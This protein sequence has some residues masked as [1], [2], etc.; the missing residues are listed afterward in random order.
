MIFKFQQNSENRLEPKEDPK[1]R[2]YKALFIGILAG[3]LFHWFPIYN[4]FYGDAPRHL[5]LLKDLKHM[6]NEHLE[7]LV[8]T[9]CFPNKNWRND[10]FEPI[11]ITFD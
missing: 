5:E 6:P 1:Y 2:T 7:M 10:G 4:D 3:S 8:N 9:E 11:R